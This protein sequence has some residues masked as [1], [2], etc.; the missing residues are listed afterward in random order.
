MPSLRDPPSNTYKNGK[1]G[2]GWSGF[3]KDLLIT[4]AVPGGATS[5]D[6][7]HR[8]FAPDEKC[9]SREF[10]PKRMGYFSSFIATPM[11]TSATTAKPEDTISQ[12]EGN[13]A[14]RCGHATGGGGAH[15]LPPQDNQDGQPA[16]DSPQAAFAG[17]YLLEQ[18]GLNL[19]LLPDGTCTLR[20]P[21]HYGSPCHFV[22][23]GDW[24]AVKAK[25][26]STEIP[27]WNLKIQGTSCP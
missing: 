25:I 18:V 11:T 1:I 19:H 14:G 24:L 17:Q 2:Q 23:D 9:W 6:Y 15:G 21:G 4:M 22:I 20:T 12:Q 16:Q 13:S 8:P 7:P 5:N 26:G 3:G 27:L 10:R